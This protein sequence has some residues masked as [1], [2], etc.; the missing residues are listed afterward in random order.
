MEIPRE[1]AANNPFISNSE[2]RGI[3]TYMW[4][5]KVERQKRKTANPYRCGDRT[6]I[7]TVGRRYRSSILHS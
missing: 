4:V 1:G 2:T 6:G 5:I 7:P 3:H